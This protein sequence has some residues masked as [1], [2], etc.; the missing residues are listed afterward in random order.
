MYRWQSA[1][2]WYIYDGALAHIGRAVRDVLSNTCYDRW[3]GAG[4]PT[5]GPPRSP[6]LSPLDFYL[7]GHIKPLCVQLLLT[8]TW[9]FTLAVWMPVRLSATA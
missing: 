4:G 5:A 3:I 9:H 2:L 6:Y 1:R 7:W 8:T